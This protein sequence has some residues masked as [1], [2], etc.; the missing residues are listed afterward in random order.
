MLAVASRYIIVA[1]KRGRNEF[2]IPDVPNKP[3]LLLY[4]YITMLALLFAD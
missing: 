4:P 2:G 3:Y 1:N